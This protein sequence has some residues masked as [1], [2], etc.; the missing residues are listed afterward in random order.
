MDLRL[1][2]RV[3]RRFKWLV[4]F[5]LVIACA[6]AFLTMVR[7]NPSTG[8]L[9]YRQNEQWVSY[10]KVFVTQRGFP[11]G[12]I[13]AQGPT[14]PGRF[15]SLAI[16]YSNLVTGDAIAKIINRQGH[17]P[18]TVEAA[19]LLTS[20]GSSDALPIISIAGLSTSKQGSLLLAGRAA[21]A[22]ISYVDAQQQQNAIPPDN[23]VWVQEI[24]SPGQSKLVSG[25]SKTLPIVAF[26]AV[27]SIIVGLAFA[28]ENMRPLARKPVP[29]D[30]SA[31]RRVVSA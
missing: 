3:L 31:A 25:R 28:L 30:D 8:K 21:T 19:A 16:I 29:Q 14:D 22:L 12:A 2:G 26:L 4:L 7:V 27:M 13:N 24:Q 1:F 9:T 18:G 6:L 15:T 20:P 5:G 23:R 17:V 11:W 10:T